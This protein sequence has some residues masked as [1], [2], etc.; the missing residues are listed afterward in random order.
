VYDSLVLIHRDA[1]ESERLRPQESPRFLPWYRAFLRA[2]ERELQAVNPSVTVPYWDFSVDTDA[3]SYLWK[4]DFLGGNGDPSEN[5]AVKNGPFRKGRWEIRVW[6]SDDDL[7][8][9]YLTR[10]LGSMDHARLPDPSEIEEALTVRRYDAP[11][12]NKA[13]DP[14]KSFRNCVEGWRGCETGEDGEIVCREPSRMHNA[15]H[16]WVGGRSPLKGGEPEDEVPGTMITSVSPN[17]PV[18]WLVHANVDRLW[19]EWQKR[20]PRGY[21]VQEDEN[22]GSTDIETLLGDDATSSDLSDTAALG[23]VYETT[24]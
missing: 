12:W 8:L 24:V 10:N 4:S 2:F 18:F 5:G 16:L 23:Y 20:H 21:N 15:V 17:D 9:P 13:S 1:F 19:A 3:D 11:P 6:E 7:R 22:P 14:R